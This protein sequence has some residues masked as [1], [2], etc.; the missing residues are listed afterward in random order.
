MQYFENLLNEPPGTETRLSY[1]EGL[2]TVEEAVA[3]VGTR[4][5]DEATAVAF[6]GS[7][8]RLQHDVLGDAAKEELRRVHLT[9]SLF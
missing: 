7:R 2:T 4:K 1:G 3:L 9:L 8:R 6:F 5:L